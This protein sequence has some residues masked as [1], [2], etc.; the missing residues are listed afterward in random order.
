VLDEVLQALFLL[1]N[2]SLLWYLA[3]AIVLL[4]GRALRGAPGL[5]ALAWLLAFAFLFLFFLFFFTDASA[6]AQ[7]YTSAN[8]LVLH[9]VPT[10]FSLLAVVLATSAQRI[11]VELEHRTR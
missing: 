11:D 7:N 5:Q 2:W 8:R 10:M 4:H 6:L 3:P 1:S 9:L